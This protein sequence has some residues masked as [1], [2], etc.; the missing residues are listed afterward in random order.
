MNLV[1][2][3]RL[4]LLLLLLATTLNACSNTNGT[5]V[6]NVK[7]VQ[8]G[9]VVSVT[10]TPIKTEPIR[11]HGG[12]GITLGSG[13]YSGIYGSFDL[14]TIGRILS[15]PAQKPMQQEIIVKRSNGSLVAITQPEK[16]PFHRGDKI[17]IVHRGNEA[18]VIH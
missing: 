5:N 13:G 11:P 14:A 7:E 12:I 9:T 15:T 3:V 16:E 4:F 1:K 18:R 6:S 17:K 8:Q 10:L 2:K